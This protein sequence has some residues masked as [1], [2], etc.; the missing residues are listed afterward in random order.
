MHQRWKLLPRAV[1][2]VK[3][4]MD[5][6]IASRAGISSWAILALALVTTPAHAALILYSGADDGAGSLATAPNSTAEKLES[7]P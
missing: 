5:T 1:L 4:I 7:E 6:Q 3:V 2:E